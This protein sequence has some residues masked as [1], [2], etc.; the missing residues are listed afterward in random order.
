MIDVIPRVPRWD[1]Y[2]SPPGNLVFINSSFSMYIYPPDPIT[3]IPIPV[4]GISFLHLSGFL[5]LNIIR[6]MK[7]ESWLRIF[8]RI[9]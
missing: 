7:N 1:P 8:Y 5:N 9:M 4:R 2:S 6:R 3:N